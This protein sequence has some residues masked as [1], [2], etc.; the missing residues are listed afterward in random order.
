MCVE[1]TKLADGQE[2]A[3]RYCW[4]CRANRINDW[5]GR[6]IAEQ[7]YSSQTLA[8]TLTYAGDGQNVSASTLVYADFQRFMKRLRKEGFNVRY[9]VAGEYGSDKGRAHWHAILFFKGKTLN[10][11]DDPNQRG[12][13]D[14][15][16]ERPQFQGKP[17]GDPL[18]R[19]DWQPWS[20]YDDN[21]FAYFQTPDYSGF[22]YILKY[23]LKDQKLQS[24]TNSFSMSKKPPL[25]YQYFEDLAQQYV[26]Q[27]LAPQSWLYAFPHI[28][29]DKN[30]RREFFMSGTTRDNFVA[31]YECLWATQKSIP[32]PY[33]E[34]IEQHNDKLLQHE[35]D[36]KTFE[37]HQKAKTQ[38][39]KYYDP[40][41]QPDL[42]DNEQL[43]SR[44]IHGNAMG[45][46]F[47][48]LELTGIETRQQT[49]TIYT[50]RGEIWHVRAKELRDAKA[51]GYL[52]IRYI[53]HDHDRS[54]FNQ[55]VAAWKDEHGLFGRDH[56]LPLAT[57]LLP[58]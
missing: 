54:Y 14:V 35:V 51:Q 56:P 57:P 26:E 48:G 5:V 46:S 20:G 36:N 17:G 12:P 50:E 25:G 9:M 16:L 23:Q 45:V 53:D 41:S 1:P 42:M 33:S 47:I 43:Q 49:A 19:I 52:K 22:Y 13:W 58:A 24:H 7:E 30:R 44:T 32:Q 39:P 21:G 2:A 27:G 37:Q 4:Q 29:D 28:F 55:R 10:V 11:V 40:T 34:V 8:V 15:F 18:A 3:C 6:A 38:W 31:A